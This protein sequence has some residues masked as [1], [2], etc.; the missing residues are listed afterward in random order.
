MTMK[1][2]TGVTLRLS[3]APPGL[4]VVSEAL[5]RRAVMLG[6]QLGR[7]G[8]TMEGALLA[9]FED[10]AGANVTLNLR[11][12]PCGTR[13][14]SETLVQAAC[15]MMGWHARSAGAVLTVGPDYLSVLAASLMCTAGVAA[16]LGQRRGSSSQEV[17]MSL[18]NV[19]LLAMAQY[20]AMD[21]AGQHL[22]ARN[23][24]DCR[25]PPFVCAEGQHFELEALDPEAW[26]RFWVGLGVPMAHIAAGW[27]PFMQRYTTAQAWLPA[28]LFD[29][30]ASRRLADLHCLA[31]DTG[32][33]V[34]ALRHDPE[35]GWLAQGPWAVD[36]AGPA[37]PCVSVLSTAA[38]PLS[39]LQAVEACRL[40]QGPL[41]GH[42]L[43]ELGMQVTKVEPLGGDPMRGMAPLVN[44]SSV[45]FQAINRGKSAVELDLRSEQ[46][47]RSLRQMV[48]DADVFMHNWAPGRAERLDLAPDALRRQAPNLLYA[49]ASGTGREPGVD[50]PLGTDFMI[51]AY[52]G[53]ARRIQQKDRIG[54]SLLTLVDLLGGAAMAEGVVA[55]LY[56]RHTQRRVAAL[57]SAMA[58][59]AGMLLALPPRANNGHAF[60]VADGVVMTD[61]GPDVSTASLGHLNKADALAAL[62]DRGIPGSAVSF[63]A[64]DVGAHPWLACA[65][66]R[67][68]YGLRIASPWNINA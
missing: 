51:Q 32:V 55:G 64:A 11:G 56:A 17:H 23:A 19:G 43:R 37:A 22:P 16:L 15:G 33:S 35:P 36:V 8:P 27:P 6:A 49:S 61:R 46:G 68:E 41:A 3:S 63:C 38:A 48:Q 14:V 29:A 34:C 53:L 40:I 54:G 7:A 58:G 20:L 1:P 13:P 57:D 47:R 60:A 30:C 67:D 50:A 44:G 5:T 42:L 24:A 52:S 12:W 4:E 39:G 31:R 10:A 28:A 62:A 59:A 65:L 66:N 45:H 2:L 21:D 25:K 9:W 18:G 26:R